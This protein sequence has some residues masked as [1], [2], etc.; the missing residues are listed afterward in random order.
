MAI[1]EFQKI[2]GGQLPRGG[3][4]FVGVFGSFEPESNPITV[5]ID[6]Q[7]TTP[8]VSSEGI[9]LDSDGMPL[10]AGKRTPL[11]VASDYSFQIRDH[12]GAKFW[13]EALQRTIPSSLDT[14]LP[15]TITGQWVFD[16]SGGKSNYATN[17]T[18]L[19][20]PDITLSGI[21]DHTAFNPQSIGVLNFIQSPTGSSAITTAELGDSGDTFV[22]T[23]A[24]TASSSASVSLE[25]GSE[26]LCVISAS[27]SVTIGAPAVILSGSLSF[28][29][30][31][32]ATVLGNVV[33]RKQVFDENGVSLGF[34]AIYDA[35]T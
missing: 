8:I 19:L 29:G 21:L 4:A 30:S 5:F 34:I 20:D 17:D 10:I 6:F 32:P 22:F 26:G 7:L 9:D 25:A 14:S 27:T 2:S 23:R 24:K 28:D 35:I 15:Q 12:V 3:K 1:I 33:N 18:T 16:I 11:Y 31:A 13:P